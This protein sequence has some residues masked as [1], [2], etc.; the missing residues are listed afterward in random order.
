MFVKF[1]ALLLIAFMAFRLMFTLHNSLRYPKR[2]K[3]HIN[4]LLPLFELLIYVSFALWIV[5]Y[6]YERGNYQ[7]LIVLSLVFLI[8]VI[9]VFFLL[10]DFIFGIY[11]KIQRKVEEGQYISVDNLEGTISR[12]GFFNLEIKDD[13]D[14]VFSLPY[15]KIRNKIIL[16]Q[17]HNTNLVKQ[18]LTFSFLTKTS[19]F[20]AKKLLIHQA[21]NAPWVAVS[22]SPFI[23]AKR[24]LNNGLEIDLAIYT[25]SDTHADLTRLMI[26]KNLK[27][28]LI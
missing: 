2:I 17:G 26:Q 25:L 3:L 15:N 24:E 13:Q 27:D 19:S 23:E 16:R 9:P 4:Y 28:L 20:E 8:L 10:R 21:L 5:N 1:I 12:A 7:S 18:V 6:Y 22:K 14:G 11:L